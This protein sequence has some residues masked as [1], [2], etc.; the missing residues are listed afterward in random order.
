MLIT[1]MEEN[2]H[3]VLLGELESKLHLLKV[4]LYPAYKYTWGGAG[5]PKYLTPCSD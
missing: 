3:K 2:F 4:N 5:I 1:C